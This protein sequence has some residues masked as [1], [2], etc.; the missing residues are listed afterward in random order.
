MAYLTLDDQVRAARILV[1]AERRYQRRADR[2]DRARRTPGD[3]MTPAMLLVEADRLVRTLAGTMA[4][5][6]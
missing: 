5:L 1:A 3:S 4:G 6:R 2:Y